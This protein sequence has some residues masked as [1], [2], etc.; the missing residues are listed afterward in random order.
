MKLAMIFVGI[1][2]TMFLL[3]EGKYLLVQVEDQEG[4][5]FPFLHPNYNKFKPF[6]YQDELILTDIGSLKEVKTN[7]GIPSIPIPREG[8]FKELPDF[9]YGIIKL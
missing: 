5:L 9:L 4:K 7:V 1:S 8:N 2:A 6:T 3:A